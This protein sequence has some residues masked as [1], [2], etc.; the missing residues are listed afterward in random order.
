MNTFEIKSA[1]QRDPDAE[2]VAG[3]SASKMRQAVKDMDI[4]TFAS[5]IPQ[6]LSKNKD[7]KSRLFAAVRDNL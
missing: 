7:F 6:H 1:G 4:K 3:M 5:G 2:G